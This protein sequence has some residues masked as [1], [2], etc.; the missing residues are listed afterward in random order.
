M[1]IKQTENIFRTSGPIGV[2]EKLNLKIEEM[3]YFVA[4]FGHRNL[5]NG[6]TLNSERN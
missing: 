6:V 1:N 2:D 4:H 5:F 3:Q